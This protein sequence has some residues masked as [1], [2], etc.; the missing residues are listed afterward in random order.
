MV[1]TPHPHA[2]ALYANKHN[3]VL[4]SDPELIA[5]AGLSA[6]ARDVLLASVP[7]AQAVHREQAEAL[8][9]ERKQWFFKPAAGF[10][11]KA[12]YRGD[13]L[14]KGT[15]ESILAGDYI[16]QRTVPP[17]ERLVEVAGAPVPLKLDVRNFAYDGAVQLV[18]ARLYHGQTTN[19]R[20]PG[21]GFAA[22]FTD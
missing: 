9:R 1:V 6:E 2:H 17:S 8:W 3:L 20:T 19:F 22:V 15:F 12:A 21:G 13:K 18:A 16:A 14:T 7:R 10:G 4:L 11:S 5:R